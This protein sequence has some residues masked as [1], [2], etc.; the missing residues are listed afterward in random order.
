MKKIILILLVLA[1]WA[2]AWLYL[3]PLEPTAE[4]AIVASQPNIREIIAERNAQ[5][6]TD[7]Q[8]EWV[9]E[10]DDAWEQEEAMLN[11]E[12]TSRAATVLDRTIDAE[13]LLPAWDIYTLADA[14][15]ILW[16]WKR[17]WWAH[18]GDVQ[19]LEWVLSVNN[20]QVIWWEILVD[21]TTIQPRD[22][23][24]QT[25]EDHLQEWFNTQ[26]HPTAQFILLDVRD[27]MLEWIMTINGVSRIISFPWIFVVTDQLVSAS[28]SFALDRN[29]FGLWLLAPWV[30]NYLELSYD[31]TFRQ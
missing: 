19:V 5:T 14:S 9:W 24:D 7:N 11:D 17:V 26:E 8:Q 25:L 23:A 4:V 12:P 15:Q 18:F 13:V 1:W 2:V 6:L 10:A 31:F 3:E 22:I 27:T 30:S 20:G 16:E 21:M 29:D 28:A